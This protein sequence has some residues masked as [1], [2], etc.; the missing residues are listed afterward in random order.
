LEKPVQRPALHWADPAPASAL[1]V[2]AGLAAILPFVTLGTLSRHMVMH[3][4]AMSVLAPLLA[5]GWA[6]IAPGRSTGGRELWA[7][8]ALQISALWLWHLPAAHYFAAASSGGTLAMHASLLIT[9]I[10]FWLS[11]V[12]LRDAQQWQGI[13]ALLITGKLACLLAGLLVFAPRPILAAHSKHD[14]AGLALNDQHLAGL[15]MI[16]ACPASYVLAGVL[17]AVRLIGVTQPTQP[18][19]R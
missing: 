9:A 18:R 6:L 13:L 10:W 2:A 19:T 3:I 14:V 5:T 16:V 1:A 11:L 17:M 8:T 12:R 4:V 15:L 7:A